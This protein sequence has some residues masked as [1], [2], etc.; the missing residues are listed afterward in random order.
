[1]GNSLES[2]ITI[3]QQP[4]TGHAVARRYDIKLDGVL[5]DSRITPPSVAEAVDIVRA[6]LNPP[7]RRPFDSGQVVTS[8][9]ARRAANR[10]ARA[11]GDLEP[12]AA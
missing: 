1:M 2:R 3:T 7:A 12:E 11:D 8:M 9:A 10:A 4:L 6:I 5:M